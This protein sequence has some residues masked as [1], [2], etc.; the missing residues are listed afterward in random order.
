MASQPSPAALAYLHTYADRFLYELVEWCKIPSISSLSAHK[1]DIQRAAEYGAMLLR[2][3]GLDNVAVLP[4]A[5]HP[6]V[7][8]EWLKARPDAPTILLYG[9]YDVQPALDVHEWESPPFDPTVRGDRLFAR[10]ASDMK[11]QALAEIKALEAVLQSDNTLPVNIKFIIEG[12]EE[13]GS[14]NLHSFINENKARLACDYA[15][16]PDAGMCAVGQ[17]SITYGLRGGVR[18]DLTVYGPQ[19]DVHSGVF[20]GTLHNPALAL[21]ALIAGMYDQ[22]G[23]VTLPGFYDNVRLLSQEERNLLAQLPIHDEFFLQATRVPA[24]WGDP[25][26][27]PYER[28]TVRPSLEV[29]AFHAGMAGE[30]VLNIVPAKASAAISMRLVPDQDPHE[31]Y[32]S[33]LHYLEKHAPPS[34]RWEANYIG[35]GRGVLVSRKSPGVQ[36]LYRALKTAWNVEPLF[37]LQG[38]GIAV[39]GQLQQLLGI[40]SVLTGFGLPDDNIHGPDEHLHLPTWY[41]GMQALVHFFYEAAAKSK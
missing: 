2:A 41:T 3:A 7:Y 37:S 27:T 40:D 19:A 24:L 31:C 38:G 10:G 5:G 22:D 35:G 23:R 11:G 14:R 13:I 28:T 16:N 34:I 29:L 25:D 32:Q 12:E 30:G 36:A 20:G 39:V 33:L 15:L 17:P 9:H 26:Y 6:V 18:I 4:T 8:G 1:M 21:S